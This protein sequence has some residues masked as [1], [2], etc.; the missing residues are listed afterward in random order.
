MID[1]SMP[2]SKEAPN[3][4]RIT[5]INGPLSGA[6]VEVGE[7]L[8]LGRRPENTLRLRDEQ[9][10]RYHAV[11]ERRDGQYFIEDLGSRTGTS[12]NGKPIQASTVLGDESEILIGQTILRFALQSP[13]SIY[14]DDTVPRPASGRSASTRARTPRRALVDPHPSGSAKL[15]L[16]PVGQ[17]PFSATF[18]QKDVAEL[19]RAG[20]HLQTLLTA[21]SIISS[22]LDLGK[23]FEKILDQIF[24]VLP[25]HRAVIMTKPT[26]GRPF[27]VRAW[28][29]QSGDHVD[30]ELIVSQTIVNRA[31]ADRVGVLTLDAGADA[32]FDTRRSIVDQNIRSALCVPMVHQDVIYGI[33]YLDTVGIT[34]AFKES[35]LHLLSG[36]AGPAGGAVRN[37]LLVAKLKGTAVDTI[38]RLAVAAEYRDDDTGFHIHRMSDY[39]EAIAH[40]LGRDSD[41]CE[42]LKLS[43]P[44]HDVGKIGIRD[45][46]LKKPA[47]LTPEEFEEMKE[48][49]IKGGAILANSDSDL[50]RM[51]EQIALTHHEKWDGSGYPLGL[52]GEQI[53]IV[54]RIVAVADVFD[55][56]TSK[57]CY[58][59]AYTLKDAFSNLSKGAGAHFDPEMIEC[60]TSIRERILAIRDHYLALEE[61]ETRGGATSDH[62]A[63]R[64][65]P[66][67]PHP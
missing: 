49:T 22:E 54:G 44:M 7:K 60:F 67:P 19:R 47:R 59:P 40:A 21:N 29:S 11:I 51:A 9:A 42:T 2:S 1:R 64:R 41:F 27:E 20:E 65:P 18:L 3:N 13:A 48:H 28:R 43:S 31:Y 36:I 37:A 6:I 55:A 53:P 5:V 39:A 50:L 30:P 16:V 63:I 52:K 62:P 15:T 8:T 45:A 14:E 33:I 34:H 10:S 17:E 35:D 61:R 23:L 26:E 56:L 58:K 24:K 57:R 12:V 4:A 38:L 66:P 25:A 46:I 32:R